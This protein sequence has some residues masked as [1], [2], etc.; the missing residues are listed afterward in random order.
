MSVCGSVVCFQIQVS[1]TGR[2]LVH[3]S[4]TE[5]GVSERALGTA[6]MRRP[7]PIGDM[8]P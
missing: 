6:T 5:C 8:E 1:A 2:S 3:R 4:P 7:R